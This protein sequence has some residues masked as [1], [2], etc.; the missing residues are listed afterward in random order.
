MYFY[1]P[2]GFQLFRLDG[3]DELD[4][5]LRAGPKKFLLITDHVQ[6]LPEQD[7][8]VP[9]AELLFRS[10]PP[11]VENFNISNW[12]QRSR[13]FSLYEVDTQQ[14]ANA[15][16]RAVAVARRESSAFVPWPLT[17]GP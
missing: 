3:Y 13:H 2:P 11:W 4:A 7:L 6:K 14:S 1:R 15:S 17:P 12:L 8:F 5:L 9:Q 16:A 10:Y